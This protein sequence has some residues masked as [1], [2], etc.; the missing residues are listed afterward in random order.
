MG[1]SSTTLH[2]AAEDLNADIIDRHRAV[3]SLIEELEA[4]DWYAQRA[5]AC[6]DPELRAILEHNGNEEKEHACMALEWL[7]RHDPVFDRHLR[8]FLFREGSIVEAEEK[9][10]GKSADK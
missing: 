3:V 9:A 8:K 5:S 1:A 2:E 10:T 7:R 4:V 6:K